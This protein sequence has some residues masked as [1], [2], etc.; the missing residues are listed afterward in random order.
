MRLASLEVIKGMLNNI[1]IPKLKKSTA[2][3]LFLCI[4][5]KQP[6]NKKL[7]G[8]FFYGKLSNLNLHNRVFYLLCKALVEVSGLGMVCT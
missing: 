5:K 6:F 7:K 2:P 8:C 3:I 4:L 1:S